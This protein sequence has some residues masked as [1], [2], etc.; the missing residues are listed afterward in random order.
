[1]PPTSIIV[2][3]SPAVE[4]EMFMYSVKDESGCPKALY[5]SS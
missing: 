5:N 4:A 2:A 1:M 3:K